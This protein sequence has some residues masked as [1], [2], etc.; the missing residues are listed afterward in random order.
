MKKNIYNQDG[1][2][3]LMVV[4]VIAASVLIMAYNASL[5]GLGE[6]EMGFSS[7]K[8]GEALAT[9]EACSEE[10]L[11][12]IRIDSEYGVGAGNI[13]LLISGNSCIINVNKS[14]NTRSILIVGTA[15]QFNKKIQIN[16][17]LTGVNNDEITVNSWEEKNN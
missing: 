16:I 14:L 15:D 9:A 2:A 7:Q 11:R 12:R 13:N 3:A 5:L 8:G 17:S 6:S 1:L 4:V 10:V